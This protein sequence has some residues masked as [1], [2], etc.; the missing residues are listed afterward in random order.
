MK[1]LRTVVVV[2][3]PSLSAITLNERPKSTRIR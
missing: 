1:R 2:P 3:L